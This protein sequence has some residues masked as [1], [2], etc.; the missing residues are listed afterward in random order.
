MASTTA[1]GPANDLRTSPAQLSSRLQHGEKEYFCKLL[2]AS[3][4]LR[5]A[6]LHVKSSQ[7]LHVIHGDDSGVTAQHLY[8][9]VSNK[10]W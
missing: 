3:D 9:S 1:E 5:F 4:L 10:G 7:C 8:R 2:Q 6:Y